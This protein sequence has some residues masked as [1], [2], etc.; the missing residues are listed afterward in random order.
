MGSALNSLE[1]RI[2][3]HLSNNKKL[4]W[5]VDYFLTYKDSQIMEV[6][7][8]INDSK[9]ECE[10]AQIMAEKGVGVDNFG[11]SDCKCPSHLFYFEKL[12]NIE[13][14]CL[15]TY[16]KLGLSPQKYLKKD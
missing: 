6:I 8:T 15:E 9:I 14:Y 3:R 16:E 12:D 2:K 13:S 11:S 1:G 7:Y 4:H 10:V 5:H